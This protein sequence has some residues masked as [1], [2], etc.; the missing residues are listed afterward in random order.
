M[1]EEPRPESSPREQQEYFAR[2]LAHAIGLDHGEIVVRVANGTVVGLDLIH[3]Y[4]FDAG[5]RS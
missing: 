4:R 5:R 3:K 1:K 2:R